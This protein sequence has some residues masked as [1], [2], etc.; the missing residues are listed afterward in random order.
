[1]RAIKTDAWIANRTV[2]QKANASLATDDLVFREWCSDT[3]Y[4]L[5]MRRNLGVLCV[6]SPFLDT[7]D[8]RNAE[9]LDILFGEH[10]HCIGICGKMGDLRFLV[11]AS[12]QFKS[13]PNY[14]L[15]AHSY[16]FDYVFP[17]YTVTVSQ[18]THSY[19]WYPAE[20]IFE[21]VEQPT[22]APDSY[23]NLEEFTAYFQAPE[24][25][26]RSIGP[27]G[28]VAQH[29][30]LY[31]LEYAVGDRVKEKMGIGVRDIACEKDLRQRSLR[32]SVSVDLPFCGQESYCVTHTIDNRSIQE[33]PIEVIGDEVAERT[34][35]AVIECVVETV[36]QKFIKEQMGSSVISLRGEDQHQSLFPSGTEKPITTRAFRTIKF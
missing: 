10:F 33:V 19:G 32:L 12:P 3:L 26:C 9:I 14:P 7:S 1:M 11:G 6:N 2:Q 27:N 28:S 36:L 15:D 23:V 8:D 16:E 13:I 4:P 35:K 21:P 17:K 5:L 22:F 31:A 25:S 18:H 34:Q 29:L 20:L 24:D 30:P